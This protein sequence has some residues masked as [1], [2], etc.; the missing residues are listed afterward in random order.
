MLC[1]TSLLSFVQRQPASRFEAKVAPR[2]YRARAVAELR[3]I[4]S[5]AL[6][7]RTC[8]RKPIWALDALHGWPDY[9]ARRIANALRARSSAAV[10]AGRSQCLND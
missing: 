7:H 10:A 4:V 2:G 3:A 1:Q 5:G 9:T 6:F 8:F